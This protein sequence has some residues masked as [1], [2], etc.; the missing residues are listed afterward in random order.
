MG[1]ISQAIRQGSV[2][3][4]I[5]TDNHDKADPI[6]HTGG[7]RTPHG[8]R[9]S[10]TPDSAK[11]KALSALAYSMEFVSPGVPL[12]LQGQEYNQTTGF[13]FGNPPPVDWAREE[14]QAGIAKLQRDPRQAAHHDARARERHG[15]GLSP[16]RQGEGRRVQAL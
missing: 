8:D 2:N 6:K 5:Y 1:A 10:E 15:D 12:M 4:I 3:D 16:E 9:C 13:D 11:A 14:D 7:N